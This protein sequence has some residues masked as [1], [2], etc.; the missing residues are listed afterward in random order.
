MKHANKNDHTKESSS[1]DCSEAAVPAAGYRLLFDSIPDPYLVLDPKL[2]IVAVNDAYLRATLTKREEILG[3]G[4]FEVFP[5]NPSETD[6]TGVRNLRASLDYVLAEQVPDTMAVQ[7]YDIRKPDEE[8]G[9]FEERY[10]SPIN[11]PVFGADNEMAYIVHRVEDVTEFIHLKHNGVEYNKLSEEMR[12]RAVQKDVEIYARSQEVA[13]INLKLKRANEELARQREKLEEV[14]GRL[15]SEARERVHTQELLKAS[16]ADLERSNKDLEMFASVTSHDLQEPLHT[17]TSYTELLAYRY[18]DKLDEKANT[19]IGY[20]VDGASHMHLLINDLL[21]Y[22]R[23]GTRAKPFAAVKMDS[24]LDQ[25][26]GSLRRSMT[27]SNATV[28]REELPE[29]EGDDTQLMQLFQNL[30]GN[31]IKYRR[32]ER[33]LQI[34]ISAHST[35]DEWIF[36]VHDNGIGIETRFFERIFGIFQRLHT[37]EEYEGSGM[38]LAICRK[39]VEHHRGRIWVESTFG[40][41]ASFYFTLPVKGENH[42][43]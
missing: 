37:R 15:E 34:R 28:E 22:S 32:K 33:P 27:E 1:T 38:G 26:L 24:T 13:E 43:A 17:I 18:K 41:G 40:E 10:W 12:E 8:G 14:N 3:R 11:T 35:G 30:I 23:V 36:G 42:G 21:A 4:M 16:N 39:I 5:D 6:S 20:I 19:Y 7:K 9:G 2:R 25:A 29:L 31:A